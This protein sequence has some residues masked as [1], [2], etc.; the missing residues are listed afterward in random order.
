MIEEFFNGFMEYFLA[1]VTKESREVVK[2]IIDRIVLKVGL[3]NNNKSIK[4]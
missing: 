4:D 2:K 3:E 1:T